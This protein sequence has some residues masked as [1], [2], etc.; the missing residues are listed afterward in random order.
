MAYVDKIGCIAAMRHCHM[1]IVTVST[2]NFDFVAPVKTG[3]AINLE[4]RE[5]HR[6]VRQL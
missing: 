5:D 1:P 2:D 6:Q 3:E 4:R